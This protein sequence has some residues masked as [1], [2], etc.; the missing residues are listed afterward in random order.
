MSFIV[1]QDGKIYQ[2]DLGPGTQAKALNMKEF[3]PG[4]GWTPVDAPKGQDADKQKQ[5]RK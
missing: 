2:A 4:P 5:A 1:N 3:D